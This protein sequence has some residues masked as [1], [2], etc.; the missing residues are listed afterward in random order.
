MRSRIKTRTSSKIL[1]IVKIAD[2]IQPYSGRGPVLN[3]DCR[4]RNIYAGILRRAFLYL[5]VFDYETNRVNNSCVAESSPAS[6]SKSKLREIQASCH[7]PHAGPSAFQSLTTLKNACPY[8]SAP[9]LCRR[10]HCSVDHLSGRWRNSRR[11]VLR[12]S[13]NRASQPLNKPAATRFP[14]H[15][16]KSFS[17]TALLP[18]T[19]ISLP[20]FPLFNGYFFL[21]SR[22]MKCRQR[23][24]GD[25]PVI[26]PRTALT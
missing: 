3:F 6:C 11:S 16:A 18:L 23:R 8:V 17:S 4:V 12:L 15:R 7:L 22:P 10:L 20:C 1:S 9:D 14:D 5:C 24:A 2:G 26:R 21:A 19:I 13:G 25:Q